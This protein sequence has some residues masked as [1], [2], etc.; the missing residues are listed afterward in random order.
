MSKEGLIQFFQRTG[1]INSVQ[2]AEIAQDFVEVTL[3][4]NEFS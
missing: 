1:L 3:A 4:K 2:A